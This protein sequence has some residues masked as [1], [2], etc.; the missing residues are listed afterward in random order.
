[1]K[2]EMPAHLLKASLTCFFIVHQK[3]KIAGG[4]RINPFAI[5]DNVATK[6]TG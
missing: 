3:S 6:Y 1:M 2:K 5:L 4:F